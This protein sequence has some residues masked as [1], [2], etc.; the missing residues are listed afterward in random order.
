MNVSILRTILPGEVW[1][2]G[3]RDAAARGEWCWRAAHDEELASTAALLSFDQ[4]ARVAQRAGGWPAAR[5]YEDA[6]KTV[7]AFLSYDDVYDVNPFEVG[8]K[9]PETR[10]AFAARREKIM[11]LLDLRRLKDRPLIAL[12]NGE[13][14]RT[15]FA[16]ALAKGPRILVLDDPAAGLDV[17]QRAKLR[18][19]VS[20]LAARGLSIVVSYRHLDEL[21]ACVTKWLTVGRGGVARET[22]KPA[23]PAAPRRAARAPRSACLGGRPVVEIRGLT[24]ACGGRKLFDGFS[25]TVRE[26]ERW[27]LRGANGSGKTTLFALVTGDSPLAYAADV[28]VFGVA[29]ETGA[30]LAK[31]RRRIGTVSP[32]M[33]ACL[34][35]GPFELIDAALRGRPRLLLLDEPFM[36]MA[37]S[38]ARAASRKIAAYLKANPRAAAV[39]VCH[40][41]DEAPACFN[42]E[43]DLDG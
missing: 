26:G 14:R 29:R 23:A 24:L 18:D 22:A 11:R 13:M 7:A 40:R 37:A 33:Q 20:A 2:V 4:H 43:M 39:M 32:E 6:G 21:P 30:E 15:L 1:A 35:K 3:G 19:V 17:H 34:G 8:A 5:Y 38:E 25:W 41:A 36:N 28:R 10:R 12:S 27:I 9:R 16:R 31:I 42:Q